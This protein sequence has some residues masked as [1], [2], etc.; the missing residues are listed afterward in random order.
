M[1]T[2]AHRAGMHPSAFAALIALFAGCLDRP[3]APAQPNVTGRFQEVSNQVHVSKIDLVFM[4]DN[5][6]SMADKQQILA[7]AIPDL[8]SRLVDPICL[9]PD[10]SASTSRPDATG[11]C[12]APTQ[13]DFDPV[14]DIHVGIISSSLGGHGAPNV[15]NGALDNADIH[16][17]DM[18]HLIARN[19]ATTLPTF[20][21]LGFLNWHPGLAG[22][23]SDVTVLTD[24]FRTMVTGVGQHG[25][26]YEA[27]LEAVYRFLVDPAPYKSIAIDEATGNANTMGIDDVVLK[28][29]ADF[30]RP[31]S[32]VA[33]IA[34]TDEN[35]YSFVDG[36]GGWV[37]GALI[38]SRSSLIESR[39][40]FEA[41]TTAC[42][43]NPNDRCCNNCILEAD[44][45]GCLP[46]AQDP[47][48]GV[49][50]SNETDPANLR[51]TR[52]KVQYGVD[53]A[54]PIDRYIEGFTSPTLDK[55]GGGVKNPLFN[56][57]ACDKSAR[58]APRRPED[59]FFFAGI[60]EVP[61]QDIARNPN[62]LSAG[63]MNAAELAKNETWSVILGDPKAS[64]PVPP[65]D[66]HMIV[67]SA[68]RAGIAG[69]GSAPGADPKNGHE[70]NVPADAN[71]ADLQYAC[72]F[73]LP[74]PR[75]CSV[76]T[77]FRD[78]DC[79]N[80]DVTNNPLCQ[81]ASGNYGKRQFAAKGYPS[82]RE[83]ELLKGLGK[84]G[85]VGSICPANT[86]DATRP[87]FGYRPAMEALINALRVP[88]RGRCLPRTLVASD[89][90]EVSCVILEVFNPAD[91][92]SC[93]CEGD[94]K[95]RG[96]ATP[97]PEVLAA[98]P[99]LEPYG[100]CVCEVLQLKGAQRTSCLNDAAPAPDVSGWCYVDPN[101]SENPA[102]CK[103]VKACEP[104][105]KRIIRY[106]GEQPRGANVIMCQEKSF[107]G[108]PPT[109]SVCKE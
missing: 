63:F 64:P 3:V 66:P 61:W 69:P 16:N 4:I 8:V 21:G 35:D 20:Q 84:Q 18:S 36:G 71:H 104:T 52:S 100:S 22:A 78:C 14:N 29:R 74:E 50:L 13:R 98:N 17:A 24:D 11:R 90:G 5:S 43:T 45:E 106:V 25:C 68:P 31:D 49:K 85:I 28:Q 67:S 33:V 72:T 105:K 102:Q 19:G 77:P 88:L 95:F 83:L 59:Y 57:P 76:A 46:H 94:P 10:G 96:R 2:N 41:G 47:R 37:A 80:G 79:D 6:A 42:L 39:S 23:H 91:G 54:W 12:P 30:L 89:D 101:Q 70:W 97:T 53:F 26:G 73:K 48:C 109:D 56:D 9:N 87:D 103:L 60:V 108:D 99:G 38:E 86:S 40:W 51:A 62:D 82:L 15:C 81:D 1:T 34:V 27:Q 7:A 75:D 92:E 58:C 44:V 65:T 93:R 55:Y 32:L 107:T